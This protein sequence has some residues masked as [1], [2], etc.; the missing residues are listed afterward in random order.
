MSKELRLRIIMDAVE[1]VSAPL[2]RITEGTRSAAKGLHEAKAHLKGLE[3]QSKLVK[4]FQDTAAAIKVKTNTIK[5]LQERLKQLKAEMGGTL[6]P[7]KA[8]VR[9]FERVRKETATLKGEK[10]KLLEKSQRLRTELEQAGMPTKELATHQKNLKEKITAATAAV[11]AQD[12]AFKAHGE[13][14]K[15]VAAAKAQYDKAMETRNKIAGAGMSMVAAGGALGAPAVKAAK[16][17]AHL[18]SAIAQMKVSMMGASGTV[19]AEFDA[20]S[21]KAVDLG[22][23][24]PGTTEEFVRVA[25]MLKNQ[26]MDATD[27]LN[28]GLESASYLGVM[29]EGDKERVAEIVAKAREAHGLTGAQ[30][31]QAADLIQRAKTGFGLTP[32]QIYEAMKYVAT[33]LNA[34]NMVGS[35]DHM[36]QFLAIEGVM[37]QKGNEGSSFGTNFAHMLKSMAMVDNKLAESRGAEGKYVRGL[38]EAQNIKF[39]FFKDGQFAGFENMVAEL[40]RLKVFSDQDQERILKK[41]FD[42]EG[43]R[44]ALTLLKDGVAGFKEAIATMDAQASLEQRIGVILETLENKYEAMEGSAN[45]LSTTLGAALAP[46]LSRLF[47]AV[48]N[49]LEKLTQWAEENPRLTS[50]IMHTV[51]VIAGL[52]VVFG[53]LA[54]AVAA[55]IGPFAVLRY[56]FALLSI[57]GGGLL[58]MLMT[59][60]RTV[61]PSVGNAIL[62]IGRALMLNPIG[63]I[64]T[65]IAGLAYLIYRYWEPIKG[66]FMGLWSEVKQAFSGGLSG[67]LQLIA[68][69]SPI[70]LFYSSMAAV[71]SYFGIELPGKF[72]EFGAHLMNGLV[73]GIMSGIQSVKNVIGG[74]AAEVVSFFKEKLGIHSPSRVFAELGGYTMQGLQMGIQ[75]AASGPLGA[76]TKTA[77][78]LATAGAV[79]L[80]ATMPALAIDNRPP[81]TAAQAAGGGGMAGASIQIIVQP[82]PGMDEAKLADLVARKVAELQHTQ[83][84]A[85]RSRL[86]DS[87]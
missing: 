12:K 34:K 81:L 25:T 31:P 32:D 70:G 18:E 61:L 60:G 63:W 57:K 20:I 42:T 9:E 19:S 40:E 54:L 8:L 68:N 44:P 5:P 66:F 77:A 21:K 50:F 51:A 10:T 64:I 71:L 24:L 37:A 76:V 74:A 11:E 55:V 48:G 72:S 78:G 84:A 53:G 56:G 17:F 86:T 73:S 30:L 26:G 23:K 41:L 39:N 4:S 83:A 80:G 79:S 43:M 47:E 59:L 2:R 6:T 62:F 85:R 52:L 33:D 1:K 15:K 75:A 87:D 28:G 46:T 3:S 49:V 58:S 45:K 7:S 22:G 65:G 27:I 38:L 82:S 14:L 67:I 13:T 69:W 16:D 29:L 35:I 36:K